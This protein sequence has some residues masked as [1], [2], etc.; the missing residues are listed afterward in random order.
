MHDA[1]VAVAA[2]ARQVI[3][4]CAAFVAGKGDAAGDQPFDRAP[5]VFDHEAARV[6]VAQTRTG[7]QR[8]AQVGFDRILVIQYRGHATLGP[9]RCRIFQ[10]E[11]GDERNLT[12]GFGQTQR[13]RLARK[14]ASQ[15]Q[16]V[17]CLHG[18]PRFTRRAALYRSATRRTAGN[19]E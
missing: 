14:A 9:A 1:A 17:E 7:H 12:A 18:F 13:K 19:A 11:L 8:V 4:Q 5:A 6:R 2:F 10:L 3:A 16:H 15:Y